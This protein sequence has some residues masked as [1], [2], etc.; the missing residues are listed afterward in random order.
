LANVLELS[1][2]R[3]PTGIS[4]N[5]SQLSHVRAPSMQR[6]GGRSVSRRRLPGSMKWNCSMPRSPRSSS[7]HEVE[8]TVD[9]L[10]S[11]RCVA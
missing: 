7:G 10:D 6:Y 4:D 8:S 5:E 1:A 3:L 11:R 9:P 2:T